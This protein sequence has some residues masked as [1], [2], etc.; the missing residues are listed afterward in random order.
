[1][2]AD[3]DAIRARHVPFVNAAGY[4]TQRCVKD[5][6]PWPCDTAI[7]LAALDGSRF[8]YETRLS[9]SIEWRQNAEADRDAAIKREARLR[10]AAWDVPHIT[11]TTVRHTYPDAV[12]RRPVTQGYCALCDAIADSAEEV[13]EDWTDK[14]RRAM[15]P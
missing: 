11:P 2:D 1:V 8:D 13:Q 5:E 4:D 3:L 6:Q 10:A 12:G 7:V 15:L 14:E 9:I